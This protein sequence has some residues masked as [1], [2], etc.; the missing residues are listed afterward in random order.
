[1][2]IASRV[3]RF[4][5]RSR[6]SRIN[7]DFCTDHRRR[8]FNSSE[9]RK[10]LFF[11]SGDYMSMAMRPRSE[12]QRLRAAYQRLTRTTTLVTLA[13]TGLVATAVAASSMFVSTDLVTLGGATSYPLALSNN[14]IAVGYSS[15]GTLT[16][17]HAFRWTQADGISDL[18][19]LGGTQSVATAVNETGMIAGA[20]GT[21]TGSQH[22]FI[23]TEKAGMADLGTLPAPFSN[24]YATGIND[25]NV[26]VGQSWKTTGDFATHGFA[27]TRGGGMVD[28]GSLGG[29]TYPNAVNGDGLVV[30]T[31]YTAGFEESRP[32][33]WTR[34]R[35][36]IDLGSLGG[37][38]GEALAVSDTGVVVGY[39]YTAGDP[40]YPHPFVWTRATGMIDL[41]TLASGYSG[42]A[43]AVN[44]DG[45]VVGYTSTIG[46]A[47]LR[48]FKWSFATGMINLGTP[49]GGDSYATGISKEGLVAG[50]SVTADGQGLQ[51]FAWTQVDGLLNLDSPV[52]GT[53]TQIESI[54]GSGRIFGFKYHLGG[55]GHA[56][57]WKPMLSRSTKTTGVNVNSHGPGR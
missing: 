14:G 52:S 29:D 25:K 7:R 54:N 44:D 1:M 24:S 38:F 57:V 10:T 50:N 6:I 36:L 27:W 40:S 19:T 13:V 26:V 5:D 18:G 43:T 45:I 56:T 34:S 31:A 55:E 30:G 3:E 20:S 8:S 49:S 9:S 21:A 2:G 46:N 41:G 53:Y 42:Y 23:W 35:G 39:S 51:G 11:P 16:T 32:F 28:I 48:A 12:P 33:A 37:H 47:E 4:D 22:A 17:S 15:L